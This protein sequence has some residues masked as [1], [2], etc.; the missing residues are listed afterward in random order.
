MKDLVTESI[1]LDLN[2]LIQSGTPPYS[3]TFAEER[4]T[5]CGE[6]YKA[7]EGLRIDGNRL[8]G[9][10][11]SSKTTVWLRVED[12]AGQ[13]VWPGFTIFK[14][15]LAREAISRIGGQVLFSD[16]MYFPG[17]GDSEQV[18]SLHVTEN[19]DGLRYEIPLSEENIIHRS[20]GIDILNL[21]KED[22]F[23]DINTPYETVK[24]ELEVKKTVHL[25]KREYSRYSLLSGE[26]IEESEQ[27]F[28][29]FTGEFLIVRDKA[30]W[31]SFRF[32]NFGTP[33][34][35]WGL[36]RDLFGCG[37]LYHCTCG[38]CPCCDANRFC[39]WREHIPEYMFN[40]YYQTLAASGNC[41]GM[42]TAAWKIREDWQGGVG[43]T[44]VEERGAF[45]YEIVIYLADLDRHRVN[46]IHDEP[47][48]L[49]TL[50]RYINGMH[51]WQLDWD[52][53]VG[54]TPVSIQLVKKQYLKLSVF[55]PPFPFPSPSPFPS[56][57]LW[58]SGTLWQNV[59]SF[60]CIRPL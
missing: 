50:R 31:Y 35:D 21:S 13:I 8:T 27:I 9:T 10:L 59:A 46:P 20:G 7:P 54:C 28:T 47:Q 48:I 49:G 43:V 58:E 56:R 32:G 60:C 37:D 25:E 2:T 3:F 52:V 38:E 17:V 57:S 33:S 36:Y 5:P 19:P 30:L 6:H 24:A 1:D 12:G 51:G 41:F 22:V 55:S 34:L 29:F 15:S 53:M 18:V 14:P 11:V 40:H 23:R 45:W 42:V 16:R 26:V 44:N 39:C 4:V